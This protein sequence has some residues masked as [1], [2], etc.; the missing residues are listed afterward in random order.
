MHLTTFHPSLADN[1]P[2]TALP[3]DELSRLAVLRHYN[4]LDS[5]AEE[6]Y[7]DL[8]QIASQICQVPIALIN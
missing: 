8:T 2:I 4:I 6:A 3:E 7:D 5:I 1:R